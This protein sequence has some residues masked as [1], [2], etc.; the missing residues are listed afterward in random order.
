MADLSSFVAILEHD[1][2]DAQAL[3]ALTQ[4]ARSAPSDQRATRL[5]AARK[6][7]AAKG[8]PDAVVALLDVE[9][10]ATP[11]GGR[12]ADLLIEKGMALDGELLDVPGARAA[13]QQALELRKGDGMATEALEDLGLSE[14][15]WQKFAAKY[16]Q[17]AT[18]STDRSLATALLVSAAECFVRFQPEAIEAEAH[19][20]KALDVDPK[21]GK[22][23]FHLARLLRRSQRWDELGKLLAD[24]A[25]RAATS[26]EKVAALIGLYELARGPLGDPP[27]AEQSIRRVLALDPAHPRALRIVTDAAAAANDWPAVVAA[28]QAALK[29]RRDGDELGMLLQISMVLW[30]H[31]GDLDGAEQYFQRIRKVEPA[32]PAALDFYRA[33]YTAKGETA[34]LMTM[35]KAAEK[36]GGRPRNE[37]GEHKSLSIEIAQLAEQQNNPE[38]AIEAWKQH[39]R[40]DPTSAQ[41]RGSLARLYRKTEKWNALLDLMKDEIER[42][43]EGDIAGRVAKMF[44]VIEI[45]R[46]RLRLDVMVINTYNAILKLDSDNVRATDEL[47]AK[48]RTLGRWNDLIAIL[49]RKAEAPNVPD[50]ERVKL[51]RE[52]A[53]LWSERFGNFANAIKP[54]ER[55]AELAPS[56]VDAVS[57]LKEIYT[58]RR[59][60]RQLIDLLGKEATTLPPAERRAKQSEM[61]RLAAERLGDSRLAIEIHNKVLGEAGNTDV[62][63][64]LAALATLYDREKL[65]AGNV[66]M[67]P[68]IVTEMDSTTVLLPGFRGDIDDYGNILIRPGS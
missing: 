11:D 19:L 40:Q 56:D 58:K 51:L 68:A 33:Y 61:A 64:T 4:A 25:E 20:R 22:A 26:E 21:N 39:L 35:L 36:G 31:L 43:P 29:A 55:I 48:Y 66:L 59:Q 30:K 45:Y 63:D 37:S 3:E 10:A 65:M 18:A 60:W 8:R 7:L 38:K 54:L 14:K 9:L 24:R 5:A 57:K 13:F 67:G 12:K 49:T 23:A 42:L 32:H 50:G 46:D 27:R 28:Y 2:D 62:G 47:A 17:E 16:L 34:K 41:A 1:P 44:D 6:S 15:N 52:V 53:D